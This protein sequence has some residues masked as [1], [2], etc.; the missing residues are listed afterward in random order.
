[1]ADGADGSTGVDGSAAAAAGTAAGCG[2]LL[3]TS[4]SARAVHW[5]SARGTAA[6][7]DVTVWAETRPAGSAAGAA[8][9]LLG[10]SPVAAEAGTVPSVT[11]ETLRED[12]G[13]TDTSSARSPKV[14]SAPSV[15]ARS[16]AVM[17]VT[18]RKRGGHVT[19]DA[20]FPPADCER[21][22]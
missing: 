15:V 9:N 6:S 20:G 18:E 5:R 3:V 16:T 11:A 19:P 4:A 7:V 13:C 1:M 12:G 2:M 8:P 21:I 14:A 22:F 10:G 17:P